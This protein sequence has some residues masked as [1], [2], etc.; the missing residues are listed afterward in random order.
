[1]TVNTVHFEKYT[2]VRPSMHYQILSRMTNIND[3][4]KAHKTSF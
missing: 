3:Y 1:M 2:K 4:Y